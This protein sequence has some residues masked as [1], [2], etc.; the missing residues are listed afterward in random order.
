MPVGD[1]RALEY[2]TLATAAMRGRGRSLVEIAADVADLGEVDYVNLT[3]GRFDLFAQ[4]PC[5][6]LPRHPRGTVSETLSEQRPGRASGGERATRNFCTAASEA[7]IDPPRAGHL[8]PAHG[9]D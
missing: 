2:R 4:V 6:N 9:R 3:A 5:R 8:N 1:P 7:A